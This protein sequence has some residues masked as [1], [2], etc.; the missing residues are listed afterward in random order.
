MDSKKELM[1][2]LKSNK[3]STIAAIIFV[4]LTI[5]LIA[6]GVILKYRA[7][8]D[9]IMYLEAEKVG[10]YVECEIVDM[11]DYF[12][13]YTVDGKTEKK[14]YFILANEGFGIL[15]TSDAK[16]DEIWEKVDNGE[17]ITVTG[18]T[19]EL[20]YDLKKIAI[21]EYN[22]LIEEDILNFSNFSNYFLNFVINE[23]EDP[24][25]VS[26]AGFGFAFVSSLF[27][28]IFGI[29]AGSRYFGSKSNINK[30][31]KEM[32]LDDVVA[33]M[34]TAKYHNKITKTII[35]DSYIIGY[36]N[37]V[38]IQKIADLVWV[39]PN[40]VR[41]NGVKTAQSVLMMNKD[42]KIVSVA[43]SNFSKKQNEA[44]VETSNLIYTC[45]EKLLV[46]YTSENITAT[47]KANIEE[48]LRNLEI[49]N[50]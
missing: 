23:G 26:E 29:I 7:M 27:A 19:E 14:Y 33:Q 34:K 31:A 42:R 11:T 47:N 36:T 28:I 45:K 32:D 37:K 39:Y 18:M 40:T 25:S 24:N 22:D 43:D 6:I 12:A 3:G 48:T 17:T 1:G 44:F 20:S 13:E 38:I 46:G 16:K 9:P 41:T 15:E 50:F 2:L 21:E 5:F 10:E 4:G 8:P 35:T 30:Y 49:S